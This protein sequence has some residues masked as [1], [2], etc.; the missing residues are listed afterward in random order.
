MIAVVPQTDGLLL[1]LYVLL[2]LLLLLLLLYFFLFF[3]R[4][5]KKHFTLMILITFQE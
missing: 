3:W 1:E 4:L 2:L 5:F